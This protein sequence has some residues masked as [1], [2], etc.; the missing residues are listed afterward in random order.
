VIT[1]QLTKAREQVTNKWCLTCKH[2]SSYHIL[3][4][5][6]KWRDAGSIIKPGTIPWFCEYMV[7]DMETQGDKFCGCTDFR[8][9]GEAMG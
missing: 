6:D 2:H 4:S 8:P 5:R 7:D 3:I 9:T 1:L